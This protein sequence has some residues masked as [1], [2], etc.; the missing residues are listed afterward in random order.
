MFEWLSTNWAGI[1]ICFFLASEIMPFIKGIKANG[2]AEAITNLF[3]TLS[4]GRE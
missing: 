1:L 3:K 2:W 4:K